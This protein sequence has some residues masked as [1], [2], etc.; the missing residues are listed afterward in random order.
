MRALCAAGVL[1]AGLLMAGCS[2]AGQDRVLGVEATGI[3]HGLVYFDRNGDGAFGAGDTIV[4]GVGISLIATGTFDTIA[5]VKSD[6]AGAFRFATVPVG[7]VTVAVDSTVLVTQGIHLLKVSAPSVLVTPGDSFSIRVAAGYPQVSVAQA[8]GLAIGAK[9]FVLGV[10]LNQQP[11][12]GDS[13]VHIADTAMALIVTRVR[14]L[15]AVGDSVRWLATRGTRNGQPTLDNPTVLTLATGANTPLH[16]VTSAVAGSA[17]AGTLDAALANVAHA[18]V[19]D[20]ATVSGSRQLTVNDNSGPLTV[21][22]DS[23]AGFFGPFVTGDTVGATVTVTGVLV[24]NG[25][26]A[27]VLL[28]RFPSDVIG[29]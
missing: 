27:W 23:V 13:T 21:Q 25:A 6:T 22:L 17:S 24:S 11:A 9:V 19:L 16:A 10:A 28:P 4:T 2:N 14:A 26:G 29:R 5:R 20:T 18:K 7:N 1:V 12:F 8:R 3:I 15:V